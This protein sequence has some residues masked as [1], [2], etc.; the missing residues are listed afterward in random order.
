MNPFVFTASSGRTYQSYPLDHYWYYTVVI[1]DDGIC[2]LDGPYG[3]I[4]VIS[5]E[6]AELYANG[7]ASPVTFAN[8][9]NL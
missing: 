6:E 9:P 7:L 5:R 1:E 2:T 8:R 4:E 3:T